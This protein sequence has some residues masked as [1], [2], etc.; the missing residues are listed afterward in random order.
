M[1]EKAKLIEAFEKAKAKILEP[2]KPEGVDDPVFDLAANNIAKN[3]YGGLIDQAIKQIK[4]NG[5]VSEQ[6]KAEFQISIRN[7]PYDAGLGEGRMEEYHKRFKE[8]IAPIM[9]AI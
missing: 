1:P 3:M 9:T 2:Y 7:Q 6:L 5:A 4:E 8:H